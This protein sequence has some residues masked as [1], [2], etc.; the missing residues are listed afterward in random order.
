MRERNLPVNAT[1]IRAMPS[2]LSPDEFSVP[3]AMLNMSFSGL[4]F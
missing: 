4:Q 3:V 1:L 2:A